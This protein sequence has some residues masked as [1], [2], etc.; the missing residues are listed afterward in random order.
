MSMKSMNVWLIKFVQELADKDG[1]QY[2]EKTI[3]Q[4]VCSLRQYLEE[5]GR[6]EANI[7]VSAAKNY[8]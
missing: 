5:H 7:H 8:W 2:P 1:D 3:Y 6:V 4:I